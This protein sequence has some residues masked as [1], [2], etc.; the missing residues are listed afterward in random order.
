QCFVQLSI[1]AQ[2]P[3]K[4]DTSQTLFIIEDNGKYGLMDENGEIW[5]EV[6]YDDVFFFSE[7]KNVKTALLRKDS[8]S[9]YEYIKPFH[10]YY[11]S[12]SRKAL[13]AYLPPQIRRSK[14]HSMHLIPYKRGSLLVYENDQCY[15]LNEKGKPLLDTFYEDA[16][17]FNHG[18]GVVKQNRKMGVI[19]STGQFIIEPKFEDIQI[20]FDG[21]SILLEEP[22]DLEYGVKK[23]RVD[24]NGQVIS[25]EKDRTKE[26]HNFL[27]SHIFLFQN[28]KGKLGL[29][30]TSTQKIITPAIY[31]RAKSSRKG[32]A[33]VLKGKKWRL[34]DTTGQQ[35]L[36]KTFDK[37][38]GFVRGWAGVWA[39]GKA[40]FI[41]PKGKFLSENWFKDI[42][43]NGFSYPYAQIEDYD[44]QAFYKAYS[45]QNISN[46]TAQQSLEVFENCQWK[47]ALMDTTGKIRL[48][49]DELKCCPTEEYP[50]STIRRGNVWGI[51]NKD[52]EI[53]IKP[54][55]Q[56][57]ILT[58]SDDFHIVQMPDSEKGE[59]GLWGL[60]D[61]KNNVLAKPQF[62][63][64]F[65]NF[66]SKA[67]TIK[68]NKKFGL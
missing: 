2:S 68:K 13:F 21:E 3:T 37:V 6:K 54:Q 58:G 44:C 56:Q 17:P 51:Y 24:R 52:L 49:Y 23:Y 34:I 11:I 53:V 41:D 30:D 61:S 65:L 36:G 35:V 59:K 22:F 47:K 40:N 19:D 42:E 12:S 63:Q 15:Y 55:Y 10:R 38:G 46:N 48:T 26:A 39:D 7:I 16:E 32:T 67:L 64:I 5:L 1:F 29:K 43:V 14:E 31:N 60:I 9:D 4:S 27:N 18:L 50:L 62:D 33:L 20:S 28:E 25:S 57:I 45:L 8:Y 66:N